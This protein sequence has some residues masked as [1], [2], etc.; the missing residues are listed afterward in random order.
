[1]K[2]LQLLLIF[3]MLRALVY[4][5]NQ[6]DGTVLTSISS[7]IQQQFSG[8]EI[9]RF[10]PGVITQLNS[11]NGF[12]FNNDRW[13]SLGEL[14]TGSQTVFGL[15]FQLPN[16]AVTFGYQ[17]I[18][19]VNPRIQWIGTGQNSGNLEF[20]V[21]SSFTSTGSNLVASFNNDLSATFGNLGSL[22]NTSARLKVDTK[23]KIG[24][25]ASVRNPDQSFMNSIFAV[26][27]DAQETNVG[28]AAKNTSSA[29]TEYAIYGIASSSAQQNNFAGFFDGDVGITGNIVNASDEKLKEN[30]EVLDSALEKVLKLQPKT[31]DYINSKEITLAEGKQYGF[32]AQELEKVFPTLV[33]Q[34]KKPVFDEQNELIDFVEYKSVN[35]LALISILTAAVQ[36]LSQEVNRLTET[37]NSYVVFSD[38]FESSEI[39]KIERLA[40]KLEQN[41]PNPFEGSTIIE[42]AIPKNE[43]NASILVFNMSGRLLKEYQLKE[44]KGQLKIS[45]ADFEPGIY[46]YSLVSGGNE[47]ITKKMII[48]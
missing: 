1:M 25:Y 2:R 41:Y 13:F 35:Y 36:D 3:I 20:R 24:L 31:Y 28:V 45:S 16:R 4:G 47:I 30:V 33:T 40:Y 46:L 37:N 32:I 17:D 48:K 26:A 9:F 43:N 42:Y 5:Q 6:S 19:D 8:Q 18:N 34:I 21:A 14:N 10:Q 27:A 12:G 39:E 22:T 15:R 11:G 29:P 38:R 23:E 7:P 44:N